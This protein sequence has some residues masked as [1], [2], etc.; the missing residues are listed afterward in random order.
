MVQRAS[1]PTVDE[2]L[3]IVAK[4]LD[5]ARNGEPSPEQ[6]TAIANLSIAYVALVNLKYTAPRADKQS[7]SGLN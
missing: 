5:D 7:G 6:A 3:A 4:T 1:T 2:L